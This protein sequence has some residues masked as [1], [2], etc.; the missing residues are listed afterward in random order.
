MATDPYAAPRARVADLPAAA[1]EGQFI[2]EGQAVA[3]G[4]GWA[5]CTEAWALFRRQ[6]GTWI[7]L[8][9]V[10]VVISIV[11]GIIPILGNIAGYILGPIVAGGLMLG[12]HELAQGGELRVGHLFAGFQ[13]HLGRLALVGVAY[14]VMFLGAFVVA[15]AVAGAGLGFGWL[16]GMGGGGPGAAHRH[17]DDPARGAGRAR[18]DDP[19]GDGDLVRAGARRPERLRRRRRAQGELLGVA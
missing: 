8:I 6:P 7:L 10:F 18:P 13:D 15:F 3:A 16:I 2:A 14:L 17:D 12:C 4:R 9:V 1:A 11:I 5:W 19:G